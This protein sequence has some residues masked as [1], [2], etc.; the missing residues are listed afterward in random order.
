[1]NQPLSIV[2]SSGRPFSAPATR[3]RVRADGFY[4]PNGSTTIPGYGSS[5]YPYSASSPVSQEMGD[6]YPV[7]R[8][9]DSEIN[10][11][12]DRMVARSRDLTRNS[13]WASGGISRI[14]DNMVGSRLRLSA[15]PDYRALAYK[16]KKSTFDAKWANEF[17]RAAEALW[18]SYTESTGRWADVQRQLT[19][20]QMFRLAAR[21]KLVDGEG[22]ALAYWLP[23]RVGQGGA[24]YATSFLL[25]DPDRLSNPYQ[26]P[27]TKNRRGGVEIDDAGMPIGVHLRKA[28]QNDWYN[29]MEANTWEFVP[30]EDEDGWR[31]VIHDFDPDRAGQ[32]RGIGVFTS[33]LEHMKMLGRYYGV[34]LQAATLAASLGTYVTSPYDEEMVQDAIAGADQLNKYQEIRAEWA[35]ERPAM[36]NGVRMPTLA[37]GESIETVHGAHPHSN[38]PDFAHE[39]LCVF[40]AAT[41]VSVEQVTQDWSRT[42]YSSAR[43]ALMETWKTLVRRRDDF[44]TNFATPIYS[45]WLNEAM[46]RGEL[47]LPAGAPSFV[48][49]ASSFSRCKWIGPGRGYVDGVKEPQG[50][51]L[52]MNMGV[53]TLENEA[54]EQ[55]FDWEEN[56]DQRQLE[57][58]A[59]EERGLPAPDWFGVQPE[60]GTESGERSH[61]PDSPN[62]RSA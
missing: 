46:D 59:F 24:E 33:V 39:M 60:Q 18:R 23:D 12:R 44:A 4:G 62:Y 16:F 47:P 31:R 3:G 32:H 7:I 26:A 28:Q 49:A 2:D 56:L 50:A 41:G 15:A 27:D 48:E 22:L 13:G 17:Q 5:A 58:K 21:H 25:M 6:W 10:I 55:G 40:A 20:G 1:M 34:E 51:Q 11:L 52:R 14:L 35:K 61:D 43:A 42:N 29:A 38:F 45:L 9:P 8:S 57:M 19:M 30:Y 36:F 37:P 53:S 54:A